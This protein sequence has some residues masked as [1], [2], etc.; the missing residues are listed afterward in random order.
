MKEKIKKLF[1]IKYILIY[2]AIILII[3]GILLALTRKFELLSTFYHLALLIFPLILILSKKETFRS[4]GFKKG[5]TQQGIAFL[6]VILIVMIGGTYLR[7]LLAYKHVSLV[8]DFSFLFFVAVFLAPISEEIFH[9]GLLQTKLEKIFDETYEIVFPAILF[10][11]IHVPKLLFAKEFVSPSASLSPIFS[12][13]IVSLFVFFVLGMLFGYIY[14][15][16][17]S[18]YYVIG[19]H[20]LYNL[21]LMIFIY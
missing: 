18:I 19:T 10:A 2:W 13:L 16:T 12:G 15:K 5:N 8:F 17:K 21:I 14:Q 4:L 11:L 20:F 6:I 9:R 1:D 3:Y 7:A